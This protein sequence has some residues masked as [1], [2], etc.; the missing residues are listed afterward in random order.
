MNTP[1]TRV[2]GKP[3]L[4]KETPQTAGQIVSVAVTATNIAVKDDRDVIDGTVDAHGAT[5]T[6]TIPAGWT[7]VPGS[8]SVPPTSVTDNADG[9]KTVTWVVDIPAA[10]VT[11]RSGAD[12]ARPTPYHGLKFRY[13]ME[14]PHLAA[15]RTEL[16]RA[17]VDANADDVID[18]HSA[19]PVLDVTRV[20][21][22]PTAALGG[23]YAGV[24]GTPIT[25]DASGSPDLDGD[26]L[27]YRW[28]C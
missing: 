27:Q 1:R 4:W 22:A 24:E 13:Q 18:A 16:P 3:P 25:F 2:V 9:T 7:V 10:D 14:S 20:N 21:T 17:E 5:V 12:F 28:A 15:G 23:P 6:D 26:S 19:I 11:G 8:Y